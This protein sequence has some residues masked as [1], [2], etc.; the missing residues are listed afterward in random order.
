MPVCRVAPQEAR[1]IRQQ[2]NRSDP[3]KQPYLLVRI[4]L[5][6]ALSASFLKYGR[7]IDV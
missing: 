2:G 7:H 6:L 3:T 5:D 4:P 1:C